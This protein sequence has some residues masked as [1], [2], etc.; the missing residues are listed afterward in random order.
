MSAPE[1]LHTPLLAQAAERPS[2]TALVDRTATLS[3]AE[4][5]ESVRACAAGLQQLGLASGDRVAVY[6]EKRVETVVASFG[7]TAA[8]GVLV[9]V[10]PVLKPR[11]VAHILADSEARFLVTSPERLLPLAAALDEQSGLEQ[12]VLVG[13]LPGEV[14]ERWE[15][16]SWDALAGVA[17]P[18]DPGLGEESLAAILY[19]SGSTG[20]PKG[21]V[22]SHA[23]LAIGARSVN[24]Y[25][26]NGPEDCLLAALPLSFDAG[27]SQL[28][29]GFAAGARV[30]LHNYLLPGDVVRACAEHG[31]TGLTCVPP[32]WM[33][34]AEREWPQ[35]ARGLRY[36][37]NTGGRMP[38]SLLARLREL[39]PDAAPFLMYGLTEAFRSTYLD[40]AEV[41]R[42]PGSIGKAIPN[43]EVLVVG[44]EG[45]LRGAGEEGELVHCGPL[46]AQ[47]YWRDP[48]RSAERFKPAPAGSRYEGDAVYSGDIVSAD[49]D[50]FLYFVG[51]DDEMIKTSGYR[52]SPTE[53]E[54]AAYASGLVGDAVALGLADERLGQRVVLA[55]SPAGDGELD[56]A[57]LLRA[58]GRDLPRFMLP[59]EVEVRAELPRSPNGK[60]DRTALRRELEAR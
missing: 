4:L 24:E 44:P 5:G 32:L 2:T 15:V 40:P 38:A 45:E 22:L 55:A 21:V 12:V 18:A 7:C 41:D 29:T 42:R 60:F 48:E 27:F 19:T 26:G 25:L 43:A 39:F 16:H 10:N 36:F 49:E 8:G 33:Q 9:P 53:V 3:Y 34:I 46:V 31:V 28:T 23:N 20:R 47:G 30:V 17:E 52:V 6:L 57:A 37:A 59:G 56:P 35:E 1:L 58:L 51:R 54:E 11:Q 13:E 14:D 50:G